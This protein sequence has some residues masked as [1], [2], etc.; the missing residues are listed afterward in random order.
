MRK[1]MMAGFFL[2]MSQPVVAAE[3]TGLAAAVDT[4][5]AHSSGMKAAQAQMRQAQAGRSEV[6]AMRLPMLSA[7]S[8]FTRGDQPVYV[9]GSLMEQGRFG[10]ANFAI[11]ALN[12]PGDLSNI[13]SGLD[14]GIP[15]FT[16]YEITTAARLSELAESE[17]QSGYEGA[18]EQIRFQTA[19]LY[20]QLIMDRDLLKSLDERLAASD[21]EVAD[22]RKLKEKGVVFG[23]DYYVAE[24]INGG[25]KGWRIQV[26][27]DQ[28]A[29]LSKLALLSGKDD[30]QPKETLPYKTLPVDAKAGLDGPQKPI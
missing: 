27:T 6:Q 21:G 30:W 22:A 14:L 5:L 8:Q 15:L 23:S 26:Q 3:S 29:A 19:A 16:G 18:A 7:H 11:D 12:H 20:L 24:A 2:Y 25:L 28:N 13:Q 17:A 4:V 9:F 10:P 1:L